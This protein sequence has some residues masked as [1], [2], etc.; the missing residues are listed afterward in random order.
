MHGLK[1]VEQ[2]FMPHI[3]GCDVSE[4]GGVNDITEVFTKFI[5]ILVNKYC[6]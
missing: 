5:P 1:F 3:L 6:T 4:D 2:A